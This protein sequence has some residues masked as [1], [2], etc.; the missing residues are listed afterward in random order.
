LK[1]SIFI[2]DNVDRI[3]DEWE[4]FARTLQPSWGAMSKE[5]LRDHSREMLM[6][7]ANDMETGETEGERK[8]K[9][10][11][12]A[13][14][15]EAPE[16]AASV[17]GALRH[18]AGFDLGQLV[19]EFRA[20]R[21]S[22]LALWARSDD[23]KSGEAAIEEITRF[24]EGID[25]ALA[26]SVERYS[27]QLG[28]SR[29]MFLAVLGHDLRSPLS[30]IEM[31]SRLVDAEDLPFP[32][33][34]KAA[35][36]I[37]RASRDMNRLITDLLEYTRS[38]LGSGIPVERSACDVGAVC[39]DAIESIRGIHPEREFVLHLSGE[40]KMEA[41]AAR[42]QQVLGNLLHNAVQHGAA[43][44]PISLK[45][46]AEGDR[47]ELSVRNF[48]KVIPPEMLAA[49]FQPLVQA[50]GAAPGSEGRSSTS[51]G[52][53]LFIVREIARAHGGDASVESSEA[54]GTVFAL[55]LPTTQPLEAAERRQE[56]RESPPSR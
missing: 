44:S 47:V 43:G 26:E 16:S 5:E 50:P 42:L 53:G 13:S 24:N 51:I 39:E 3:V 12:M 29:D 30:A 36:R 18:L 22:V 15:A 49:V 45:C 17:H 1:L 32:A 52:L 14:A 46:C 23:V 41:D 20:M 40:L 35:Q 38:R 55:S 8:A 7:V 21:A 37:Q 19:A 33:R 28:T 2:R 27:N 6:A 56:N 31:S 4:T 10:K 34:R 9:S 25:M 11:G 48:G 54:A